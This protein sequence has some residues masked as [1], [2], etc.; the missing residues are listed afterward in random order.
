MISLKPGRVPGVTV[1]AIW[2]HPEV[3]RK[4][5]G[6]EQIVGPRMRRVPVSS[7]TRMCVDTTTCRG[8]K[9]F[10]NVECVLSTMLCRK[11]S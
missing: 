9:E 8:S 2:W 1:V 5:R 7:G 10:Y 3:A 6:A 11:K 4:W